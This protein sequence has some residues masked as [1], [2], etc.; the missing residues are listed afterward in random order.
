MNMNQPQF[1]GQPSIKHQ[2]E[3]FTGM[4]NQLAH[5]KRKPKNHHHT[6]NT[7]HNQETHGH[8]MNQPQAVLHTVLKNHH[9]MKLHQ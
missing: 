9:G 2:L 6:P 7:G 3:L 8:H 4:T 1:H 5:I